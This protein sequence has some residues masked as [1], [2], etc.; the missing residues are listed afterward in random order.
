M[1]SILVFTFL[2]LLFFLSCDDKEKT[3]VTPEEKEKKAYPVTQFIMGSDLSYANV[4]EEYGA[5]YKDSNS[6]KDVYEIFKNHG[7]NL[8]RIRLWH[9][10]Q[11]QI[12][13]N[14]SIKYSNLKDVEK[15]IKRA[16]EKGMAV[17]L[18]FHYSDDWADPAR[19]DIPV[20]WKGSNINVMKDSLY[21]YTLHTLMYLSSK[22]LT[23]EYVQIGNENN[24]GMLWPTGKVINNDFNNFGGF[25]KSGINAVRKFSETSDI[26]PK[27][28][29]HVAQLQN[30]E[31]WADGVINKAGVTDFDMIGL[32]HYFKWSEV[33]TMTEIKSIIASLYSKYKKDIVIVETAFP[34]TN[35]NADSYQNIFSGTESPLGYTVS[36]DDQLRYMKDLTQTV[37]DG[38]GKGIIYWEPSW[39]STTFKDRWGSGSSWENNAF[40]DFNGNVL[41]AIDYMNAEYKF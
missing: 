11:W 15:S 31:W 17:L 5:K 20:A 6:V 21:N 38:G 13:V 36:K 30:A 29:L 4:M 37:I 39:I 3:I 25:L 27:I 32:S 10:P 9:N 19:Q 22:N 14:G 26:K 34:W 1:K 8:V 23:P 40:F 12:A 33:K 35:Q 18:D 16:K 7:N 41:P 24:E 2:S 28:I